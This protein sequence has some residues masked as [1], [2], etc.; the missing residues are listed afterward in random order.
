MCYIPRI[1]AEIDPELRA[2]MDAFLR[3][4]QAHSNFPTRSPEEWENLVDANCQEGG[5][6]DTIEMFRAF[7]A[8]LGRWPTYEETSD[9]PIK[10]W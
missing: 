8:I 1:M 9:G 4:E 6:F 3:A 2:A 10:L 5:S 7:H